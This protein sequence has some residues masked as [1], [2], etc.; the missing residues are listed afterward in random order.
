DDVPVAGVADE[1][2]ANVNADDVL[3]AA[4]VEPI[5][6]SLILPTQPPPRSQDL[7]STLQVKPTPPPS[8]IAQ[9]PSPQ[10]QPQPSLDAKISMDLLHNLLDTCTTLTKR[11]ENLEQDKID[12]ALEII[13]LKQRVKK[14][15][16]R[17]KL[18]V[19]K[20]RRLKKVGTAQRVD[21]SDDI[22][23]DDVSKQGR[24]IA[25]MDA[26]VDV[27]LKDVA[28]IAKEVVV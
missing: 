12:Q 21:T 16:R 24:I 6:S 5:I 20:L 15:E 7:P 27:T 8:P 17:N 14:L 19:S 9:P 25:S 23:M 13:K 26:N 4:A 28:N 1:G 10:Q 3:T 22:V 18:K 2:A 11:V